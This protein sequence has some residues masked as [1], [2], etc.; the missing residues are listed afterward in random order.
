MLRLMP[1]SL[2][3]PP[4]F[5]FPLRQVHLDFHTSPHIPDVGREFDAR[6]FAATMKRAHVNS[7]T[8]FAK[9]HH[10]MCYFP[11]KTGTP[12]PALGG[13]DQLGEMIE[14]LHREG[15]RAPI[16]T[17]VAWE[18]DVA[19]RFPQWRQLRADGTFAR[20]TNAD[21]T[22][23]PHPGGW[24]FNDWLNPDYQDY[25]EA[26][27]REICARYAVDGIFYDIV[28]YAGGAHH[29]DAARKL[30]AKHKL[31]GE[32]AATFRRFEA[33]AQDQFCRRFTKLLRG[34]KPKASVFYNSGF[35]VT[36]DA[37]V[38]GR[39]RN[40]HMTHLEIE[41]LPSGF[42]GYY[43]FPRLARSAGHWGRP[44][45]G[46]TGRFQ[47]MW[48][49][50]GGI[51]P[52]PALE[53]ECFRSQALGGGNSVGDQLPPRGKLDA[54]AYALI[55]AVYA[56]CAA[57][58][59][60]YA[61]SERLC[62]VGILTADHPAR[63]AA[64][65]QRS[66]E[67]AIQM[68]EES[69]YEADLLDEL[70][71]F[72]PYALLMLPDATVISPKVHA[73]LRKFYQ[74][75]GKLIVSHHG[76]RDAAG[77][78]ALDFLPLAFAGEGQ[79]FPSYWRTREDFWAEFSA[80]DRVVYAQG[81]NVRPGRGTEILVDRVLPYF[82]RTDL[83]FSSHFQ[84]PP[85]AQPDRFPAVVAGKNFVYFADPIF[86][87]YR[88]AGNTAV[89][90]VWRRVMARLIGPASLGDGLPTTMLSVPR[91]RKRDLILT[92]LHYIPLRKALEVDVLE[93]RMGFAGES[94]RL[95]P[96]AQTVRVFG[97]GEALP[98]NADGSFALPIAKGRLLL[99]VPDFF[100]RSPS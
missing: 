87:E 50:F 27:T 74:R 4:A 6:E 72:A 12:H 69:H 49:D 77:N 99:E 23:P 97:S 1:R 25:I 30:R 46:M 85:V 70:D 57:A 42:W 96:A 86:R 34:L 73:K 29:S 62:Q 81:T 35:D 24:W 16:Y 75:G 17:T 83:T 32:D 64:R 56:Q 65:A 54:A 94:L 98:R 33:L 5:V 80:S 15:I 14:A 41:S 21:P 20:A 48:G 11:T 26:H 2:P 52:Q 9:C 3:T 37:S 53:F 82:N 22:R 71:D 43:H 60:F 78:W 89:R 95:P 7:V 18:E 59:P 92:L 76:G 8:V 40:R 19:Q 84:T 93:E 58:E 79:L 63:D 28:F 90:D 36:M 100:A 55:G 61:G 88:E 91:R 39:V 51:K 44:W 10:G 13:R 47:K 68:C 66:D 38:G 45:L 31:L 67:G